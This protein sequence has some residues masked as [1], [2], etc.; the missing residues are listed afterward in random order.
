MIRMPGRSF[1][2]ALPSLTTEQ[3]AL[4]AELFADVQSLAG[5]IGQRN[6]FRYAKLTAAAEFIERSFTGAGWRPRRD[7]YEVDGKICHNIEVELPGRSAE[8][9]LV[10]A[11]YDSVIGAPGANDNGTGVAAVLALARRFSGKPCARTLRFV[12][13]VNEEPPHFQTELMGSWVYASRCKQRGDRIAAM[14][15]LETIGCFSSHRG[16]QHYPVPLLGLVYPSAGN[17]IA[18]VGDIRSRKLVRQSIGSFRRH[19]QFPSEG[20]A[21][22]AGIPGIG[23]SDHWSFWQHGYP[24]IMITDTAPFR[25]PHYHLGSDTPEQLDYASMARVVSGV[26]KVIRDLADAV[27]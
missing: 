16:S 8:V 5:E 11:H 15:S 3:S 4:R 17:F 1:T 7:S 24:A 19:T 27:E 22:P 21:L 13:F 2:G 23:W 6:V 12:A 9:I 26:E 25:Y 14:L 20:A 10:G 18:F